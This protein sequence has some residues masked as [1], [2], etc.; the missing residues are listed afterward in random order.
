MTDPGSPWPAPGERLQADVPVRVTVVLNGVER[1]GPA[2]P[3][4][5][6]SDFLRHVLGTTSMKVGCE[7][8]TCGACTIRLDGDAVNA[9]LALAVQAHGRR[10]DT[11]EGLA[12]NG[13]L[14][15]LQVALRKHDAVQCGFCTAGVLMSLDAYLNAR[16]AA[17]EADLRAVLA[18]HA[19]RCTGYTPIV[20]AALEVAHTRLRLAAIDD[21]VAPETDEQETGPT[22]A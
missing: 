16:P 22:V 5:L 19:C 2:E 8:G 4:L 17:T 7:T 11:V 20:R 10:V 3:R 21:E 13:T 9:C 1:S 15:D 14:G 12:S 6:L 18:G